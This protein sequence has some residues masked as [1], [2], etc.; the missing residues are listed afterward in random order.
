MVNK[1]INQST[2]GEEEVHFHL[3]L[4]HQEQGSDRVTLDPQQTNKEGLQDRNQ[5]KG[6]EYMNQ[7]KGL[8]DRNI[9]Q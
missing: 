6:Q 9:H 1:S 2:K 7:V 5:L 8:Q 3:I 4:E